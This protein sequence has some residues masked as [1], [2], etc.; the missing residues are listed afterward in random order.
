MG[1]PAEQ[2]AGRRVER[3]QLLYPNARVYLNSRE[4]PVEVT[5]SCGKVLRLLALSAGLAFSAELLAALLGYGTARSVAPM[6]RTLRGVLGG[7]DWGDVAIR[8][9]HRAGYRLD[10]A[11][12]SVD[13]LDF[14]RSVRPVVREYADLAGLDDLDELSVAEAEAKFGI[15]E[16]AAELWRANPA[17]GL[18][19]VEAPEYQYYYEFDLLHDRMLRLQTLLAMR[20]GSLPR[21]RQAIMT[22]EGRVSGNHSPESHDW[23]LLIRA[24]YSTGNPAKVKETYARAKRHYDVQHGQPL[25]DEIEEYFGRANHADRT[26]SLFQPPGSR[27]AGPGLLPAAMDRPDANRASLLDVVDAIGITTHHELSLAGSRMEPVELMRRV[28]QRLWFSGVLASKWVSDL[29]VRRELEDFLTVLDH[30]P[31]GD[32][33]FMI[34]NPDA[35]RRLR[36]LRGDEISAEHLPVLARLTREHDSFRVKVFS[37]LPMF[38]IHVLDNDVVTFRAYRLDEESYLHEGQ[39]LEAPHVVLDPLAP[40]PLA[41]AFTSLFK[42]MWQTSTF[43]DP[44]K[45]E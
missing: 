22:L 9:E 35:Y 43:L 40:W 11:L 26:F 5:G 7:P 28:R 37:H 31:T 21:L 15:L 29:E 23:C 13:A 25:P 32:V 36:E 34:M 24:Y 18:E 41:D 42:E 38:R 45:Y 19:D 4:A 3:V 10:P 27:L 2:V 17:I 20:I 33:R 30:S 16:A 1:G 14:Q 12:I 8:N 6:I 44:E 39:T